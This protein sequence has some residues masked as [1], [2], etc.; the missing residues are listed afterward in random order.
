[1]VAEAAD[2]EEAWQLIEELRPDVA[3]LD[4]RLP[5]LE[6]AKVAA[7]A[8]EETV[9]PPEVADLTEREVEVLRLVARGWD[10]VALRRSWSSAR[11]R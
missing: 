7:W 3:L 9:V 11:G 6:G 5:G 4:C 10:N 1:M 8:R 2:G